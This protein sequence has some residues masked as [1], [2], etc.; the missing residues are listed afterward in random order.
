[1]CMCRWRALVVAYFKPFYQPLFCA[2]FGLQESLKMATLRPQEDV[3]RVG[4]SLHLWRT[5]GGKHGWFCNEIWECE[6][7]YGRSRYRV[8]LLPIFPLFL[9]MESRFSLSVTSQV[10]S[11]GKAPELRTKDMIMC[12][13][14]RAYRIPQEAVINEYRATVK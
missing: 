9:T 11:Q 1:M 13:L 3:T 10:S 2:A 7:K 5:T 8:N 14:V 6:T 12:Y 4:L